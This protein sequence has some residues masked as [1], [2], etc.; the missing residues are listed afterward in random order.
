MLHNGS[1]QKN[2]ARIPAA[3]PQDNS[4]LRR[5]YATLATCDILP[6]STVARYCKSLATRGAG[7]RRNATNWVSSLRFDIWGK[8]DLSP[9]SNPLLDDQ[10]YDF[11]QNLAYFETT[12]QCAS[13]KT[14]CRTVQEHHQQ[15]FLFSPPPRRAH[16]SARPWTKSGPVFLA[17]IANETTT[18][19]SQLDYRAPLS[20]RLL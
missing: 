18:A 1:A 7:Q 11:L 3:P 2:A 6:Q 14:T 19:L 17:N 13:T 9:A 12:V 20:V 5:T 15:W 16:A 4:C 8:A 10:L